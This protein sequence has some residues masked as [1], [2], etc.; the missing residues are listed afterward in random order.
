METL[1][2]HIDSQARGAVAHLRGRDKALATFGWTG[3]RAAW[4]AFVCLHSGAFTRAQ[5]ARFLEAHPEQVRRVVHALIAQGLAAEEPVPGIRGDRPRVPDLRTDPLPRA[6]S[7]AQPP[8]PHGVSR[9]A[10]A[11]PALARLCDR[12]RGPALACY[13]SGEG[14]RVRGPRHRPG[15]AARQGV[16]GSRRCDSALLPRSSCRSRWTPSAPSSSTPIPATIPRPRSAPGAWRTANSGTRSGDKAGPWRSSSPR[17]RIGRWS[18]RGRSCEAG[19]GLPA[20]PNPP[21]RSVRNSTG[22]SGPFSR[23]RS[24]SSEEFGGLQAAMKRSVAL[25]K[26]ARRQAVHGSIRRGSAWRTARLAGARY[27]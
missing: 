14:R 23:A 17:A 9:R 1:K 15:A 10:H 20:T 11:A 27:R 6:R 25:T 18:G 12:A 3:E 2:Q 22:S 8:P 26:Q 7:R 19:P 5:C 4:I 13:R 16:P 21:P 24:R